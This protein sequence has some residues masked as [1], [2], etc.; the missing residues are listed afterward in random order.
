M[1]LM[2]EVSNRPVPEGWVCVETAA[3][4]VELLRTGLVTDI[5]IA[6]Y[7]D[8]PAHWSGRDVLEFIKA[9][10]RGGLK[11][12]NIVVSEESQEERARMKS[13]ASE[14]AREASALEQNK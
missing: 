6:N 11:P 10:A 7:L 3:G 2:I 5:S 12:P 8:E 4:A 14:I 1:K 9:A 13:L